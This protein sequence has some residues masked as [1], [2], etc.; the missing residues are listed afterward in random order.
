[1]NGKLKKTATCLLWTAVACA[2]M[3]PQTGYAQKRVGGDLIIDAS[4]FL[5]EIPRL[6]LVQDAA[7]LKTDWLYNNFAIKFRTHASF[8]VSNY[9]KTLTMPEDGPYYLYVRAVGGESGNF[10]IRIDDA[11][12][13]GAFGDK[14]GVAEMKNAGRFDFRKGQDVHLMVTRITGTPAL[15]VI[16]FSKNPALTEADLMDKQLPDDVV[17]LKEYDIP[18]SGCVKFGDLTGDG[19]TDFVVMTPG[20]S[21]Y[22]YDNAG[23]KLWH[24]EAPEERTK[25]RAEFEAPGAVWD[26][27]RDGR[28]ELVQWRE[29][30]GKEWLVIADGRTGRIKAKTPWPTKEHPHV[31]NNF[32][33]AIANFNGKYP[34]VVVVY[35]DC[36]GEATIAA[37]D[38]K[39]NRL[40]A[41]VEHTKKDHL[42]HYVY[43]HDFDGDGIDE[44]LG[45]WVL[46]DSKGHEIWNRLPDIYDNHDHVDSYKFADMDGDGREEIVVAACDLGS[47]VREAMTGKLLW[48]SP[49]EHNQQ[50]QVGRFL[51]GYD[52]PQVAAGARI[53]KDRKVDPY[54]S[55][56]VYW[57]DHKGELISKWPANG[58]N[59][60]PDFSV[61]DWFGN[62]TQT[63]F[64]Y[65]FLMQRDGRG[66]LYFTGNVY[67]CFDFERNGAAQV[68]TLDRGKLRV[69]GYKHVVA[70]TPNDDP[71]FVRQTMT[72]HTHY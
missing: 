44:V 43:P 51:D 69:W 54:L 64:W 17:L 55:G 13:E 39:L 41:H 57:F 45:G 56:Q 1:M 15:D 58:L 24:W 38:K 48:V 32:R 4:D 27:D 49:S 31:Y 29:F 72:N 66:K 23:K 11:Y 12:V 6:H 70:K 60:N 16:V 67:H 9:M 10:R 22:A 3:A 42:G 50:I 63:L 59:G 30:D 40:W 46:L 28:A 35:S 20:Y 26:F 7:S 14:P 5:D 71:D 2:A 37:Y 47:Q 53:Y 65:K 33:I 25:L 52:L 18:A 61:G 36:G 19:K 68:I 21:S 34:D 62:G 8:T